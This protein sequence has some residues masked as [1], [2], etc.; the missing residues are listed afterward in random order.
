TGL[1]KPEGR[2]F[3]LFGRPG[4]AYVYLIYARYWLLNVVT[5]PEGVGGAVL[6]RA[7]EPLEGVRLMRERRE[8]ARRD[9]DLTNGPG[10]LTQAFDVDRRFH[11]HD[12]AAPPL[13]VAAGEAPGAVGRS[14]R[15]GLRFG[16][17]LPYRFFVERHPSVSPGV[18]SDRAR[19]R[20]R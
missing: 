1:L 14:A 7:V 6:I 8:A 13:F 12:L 9:R 19:Q 10:K 20:G 16:T 11:G 4:T 18:P 3:D 17:D 2:G 5:E 15:I